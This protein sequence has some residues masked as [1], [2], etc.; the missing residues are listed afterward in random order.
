MANGSDAL[1]IVLKAVISSC[2]VRPVRD[3]LDARTER[4]YR[5]REFLGGPIVSAMIA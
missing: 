2:G 4:H 5:V 1:N 3:G